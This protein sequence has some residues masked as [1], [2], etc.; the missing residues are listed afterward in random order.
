MPTHRIPAARSDL[1]HSETSSL[2]RAIGVRTDRWRFLTSARLFRLVV[3]QVPLR[4]WADLRRTTDVFRV[5]PDTLCTGPALIHAYDAMTVVERENIP[6]DVVECGVWRGGSIGLMAT[7]NRRI[8][9]RDRRFHLFDSFEGL[10]QPSTL[11]TDVADEFEQEYP[12]LDLTDG[13]SSA[14]MVSI[15][16]LA[17]TRAHVEHLLFDVL[18]IDRRQVVIHEGWFQD[19]M[20]AAAAGDS[21]N[22]ISLLCLDGDWYESV[23]TC[24]EALYDPVVP[25][26]FVIID[27]YDHSVGAKRATDDFLRSRNIDVELRHIDSSRVYFRKPT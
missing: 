24:L 17:A 8:G 5:L 19:T 20:P 7:V 6:G 18:G 16:R 10:P 25:Q 11:D 26:G 13:T 9:S 12:D 1:P 23:L 2:R 3:R 21:L 15:G 4:A 27:D 22:Q 14:D